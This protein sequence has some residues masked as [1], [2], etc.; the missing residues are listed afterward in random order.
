MRRRQ[1]YKKYV[2][3]QKKLINYFRTPI[4]P[5]PLSSL[6]PPCL[7]NPPSPPRKFFCSHL[8]Y[9][10]HIGTIQEE[11]TITEQ[12]P[13]YKRLIILLYLNSS[14]KSNFLI[15]VCLFNNYSLPLCFILLKLYE[16]RTTYFS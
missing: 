2:K 7:L 8:P 5:N 9:T 6:N 1:K 11:R 12:L 4:P 10:N 14:N 15:R 16:R 3:V 13:K